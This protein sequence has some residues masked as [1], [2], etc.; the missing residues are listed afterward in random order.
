MRSAADAA[1]TRLDHVLSRPALDAI[2]QLSLGGGGRR[3]RFICEYLNGTQRFAPLFDALPTM[4]V[5]RRAAD[6]ATV[7]PI[8]TID[9]AAA[10]VPQASSRWLGTTVSFTI[11][12]ATVGRPGNGRC[13]DG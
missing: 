2:P 3:A 12:E 8:D 13:S 9:R 5:V 6:F 7:E 11:N 1:L 10:S 4:L